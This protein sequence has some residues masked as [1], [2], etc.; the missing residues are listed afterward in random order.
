[1]PHDEDG[2]LT[3][4]LFSEIMIL[5]RKHGA[6]SLQRAKARQDEKAKWEKLSLPAMLSCKAGRLVEA[7][8]ASGGTPAGSLAGKGAEAIAPSGAK[9][10]LPHGPA[11]QGAPS[12]RYT[13][14]ATRPSRWPR[15]VAVARIC[16]S[17]TS[18]LCIRRGSLP[19]SASCP[20][21]GV[22]VPAERVAIF[23][24]R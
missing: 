2:G 11:A 19:G 24:A 15:Y 14:G 17:R 9:M 20:T 21:C 22:V 23:R 7:A 8:N 3:L 1:M 6:E 10:A 12:R 18:R 4:C 13:R 5:L 16:K